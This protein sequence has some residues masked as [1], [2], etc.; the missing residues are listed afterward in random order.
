MKNKL[1][2][3]NLAVDSENTS[4]AFTQKWIN[5]ISINY[6]TVD[7]LTMKVGSTYQLNKNVYQSV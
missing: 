4:L 1:L 5:D 6:D 7:V 2:I 3:L